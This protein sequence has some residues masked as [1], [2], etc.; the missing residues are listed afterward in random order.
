MILDDYVL[1]DF[2]VYLGLIVTAFVVLLLVFTV[3]ELIG[4]ILRNHISPMVVGAYLLNVSPFFIYNIA[5][6]GIL[7][8]VLITFG[9]MQR[10]E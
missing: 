10:V 6:L 3:F 7:L 8:A 9:L 5:P 4:D 1:R 2:L